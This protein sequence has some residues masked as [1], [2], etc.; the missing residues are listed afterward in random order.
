[1]S[2]PQPQQR[3]NYGFGRC[4]LWARM[5]KSLVETWGR[6]SL[7]RPVPNN[8][9]R[10]YKNLQP[11]YQCLSRDKLVGR[12]L[13]RELRGDRRQKGGSG[14]SENGTEE[15]SAS[16]RPGGAGVDGRA[17]C[18]CQGPQQAICPFP[19]SL[20]LGE[21]VRALWPMI[22]P[23]PS[24]AR[25]LRPHRAVVDGDCAASLRCPRTATTT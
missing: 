21:G 23:L 15:A 16:A 7:L 17:G 3:I 25:T 4:P 9:S 1:M 13:T 11:I 5:P 2:L 14:R 6:N 19:S 22:N 24:Q 18:C 8:V 12:G 10:S 20:R